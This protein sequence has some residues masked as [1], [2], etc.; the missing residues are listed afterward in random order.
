LRSLQMVRLRFA[1]EADEVN[2]F[3]VLATHAR[4][5]GLPEGVYEVSKP[6]LTLLDENSIR[7]SLLPAS[8]AANESEAIRNPLT[9]EL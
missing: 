2:G 9:V 7:Y 4:L 3:Y 1:S 8:F 5:R 6:A